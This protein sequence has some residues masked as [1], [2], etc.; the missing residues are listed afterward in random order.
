V[1]RIPTFV[2]SKKQN[3][4]WS[5]ATHISIF[6][7]KGNFL[8]NLH[9]FCVIYI[10]LGFT[11]LFLHI[12]V[13][14]L[15]LHIFFT[16]LFLHI[17][18]LVVPTMTDDNLVGDLIANQ[19]KLLG[20]IA[21]CEQQKKELA[22]ELAKAKTS[23]ITLT[24]E[25]DELLKAKQRVRLTAP[26]RGRGRKKRPL[27]RSMIQRCGSVAVQAH[28]RVL[29]DRQDDALWTTQLQESWNSQQQLRC[30]DFSPGAVKQFFVASCIENFDKIHKQKQKPQCSSQRISPTTTRQHS[31]VL[32]IYLWKPTDRFS[33][34][35]SSHLHC[36]HTGCGKRL[37][38]AEWLTS[39]PQRVFTL[40]D[41]AL[42]MPVPV[43]GGP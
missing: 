16:H 9:I 6:Y 42:Y 10:N 32:D 33:G 1:Q 27:P 20:A 37:T 26:Q 21:T 39:G 13:T 43:R 12:F 31:M 19:Q 3:Q 25:R 34:C 17:F 22:V 5:G 41:P 38:P 15:F 7:V 24:A 4:Q 29:V 36:T 2:V 30:T 14:H 28:P 35:D 18:F 23:I 8:C 40:N 11:H